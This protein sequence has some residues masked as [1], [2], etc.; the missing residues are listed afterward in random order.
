[1][2]RST[3]RQRLAEQYRR[4]QRTAE[5]G[6]VRAARTVGR[7][8]RVL[9]LQAWYRSQNADDVVRNI[10]AEVSDLEDVFNET[11]I[12]ATLAGVDRA[13]HVTESH[14]K[15]RRH[16]AVPTPTL[17]RAQEYLRRRLKLTDKQIAELQKLF[18]PE[19]AR[20]TRGLSLEID[21][22]IQ[23]T[24][25]RALADGVHVGEGAS[26][27]RRAFDGMGVSNTKPYLF[28]TLFRTQVQVAY[29]AGREAFNADPAI[30]EILW[31][32]EYIT[33]GDDRVRLNHSA[34]EGTILPKNDATWAS[35]TPPN[36]FSCRCQ[37]VEVFAKP[38]SWKSVPATTVVEGIE[39]V[40][41]ADEGWAW[42]PGEAFSGIRSIISAAA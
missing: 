10:I 24:V 37:K 22:G 33:A 35:I 11:M 8:I 3:V 1:M 17:D 29:S 5:Q 16:L 36:G 19:A 21:R 32:Y 28:E 18:G 26:R 15:Q 20:V 14:V 27:L 9:A 39:V 4:D 40:P 38:I 2:P 34:L 6:G 30:D 31:G 41:G 12:V 13:A 25:A 42:N 23:K 7:H